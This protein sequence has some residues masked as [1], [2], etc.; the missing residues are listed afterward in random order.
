MNGNTKL[1]KAV[2]AACDELEQLGT[3]ESELID[4]AQILLNKL[5]LKNTNLK[6]TPTEEK[7]NSPQ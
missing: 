6:S 4:Q 1:G 2:R 7:P 5:G 3:L